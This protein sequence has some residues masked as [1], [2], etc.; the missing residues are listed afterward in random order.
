MNYGTFEAMPAIF[1]DRDEAWVLYGSKA[2]DWRKMPWTEVY[3]NAGVRTE[4][5]FKRAFPDLP[6][7]PK[8]A[9]AGQA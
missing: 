3:G 2:S 7:L 9:F 5:E 6:P 1:N 4:A 8:G